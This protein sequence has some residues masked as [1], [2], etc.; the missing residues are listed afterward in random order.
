[1]R[2]VYTT[3]R[4]STTTEDVVIFEKNKPVSLEV[5]SQLFGSGFSLITKTSTA[6]GDYMI[7]SFGIKW[8]FYNNLVDSFSE[9]SDSVSEA[10]RSI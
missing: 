7:V 1:M 9:F 8:F 4:R 10:F 5:P 6:V 3:T 2:S